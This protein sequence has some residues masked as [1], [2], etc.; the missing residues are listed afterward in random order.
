M[1]TSRAVIAVALPA[2][3][4]WD[5]FYV[6]IGSSAAALTGLMFVVIALMSDV[7][8]P[9]DPAAL[10]AF[11]TPTIV[12]F[13]A[14]VLI[15]AFIS[16]PHRTIASLRLCLLITGFV[17]LAYA[18]WVTIKALRQKSY[19]P[20]LED[21][22]FHS[23]LPVI[24]YTSIF[25]ASLMLGPWSERGLFGVG[26]SA[27]LLLFI[28]IHNAWD[29]A[30]WMM[31]RGGGS[32]NED[33]KQIRAVIE[34][35]QRATKAGDLQAVLA[36]MADDAVFLTPGRAPMTKDAFATAFRR[37]SGQIDQEIKEIRVDGGIAYCWSH[38]TL[39]MDGKTRAG[40]ILTVFRKGS[41]GNWVLARDSNLLTSA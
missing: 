21:W 17:G 5:N 24:A 7:R 22:I 3:E 18:F 15:A 4:G 9:R 8:V 10:E 1:L 27:L 13:S 41:D 31:L 34:R 16:M 12:H 33:E 37:V 25:I 2:V 6:I 26:G 19:V 35:W 30:V 14:V 39:T 38:L 29:A 23:I 32:S 40:H 36:L 11:A 28:G 20:E